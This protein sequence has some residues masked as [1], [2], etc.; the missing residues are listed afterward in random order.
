[1]ERNTLI[2]RLR[3]VMAMM[4]AVLLL[5]GNPLIAQAKS[6][7]DDDILNL[8]IGDTFQGGD[9]IWA[10]GTGGISTVFIDDVHIDPYNEDYYQND[11]EYSRFFYFPAGQFTLVLIDKGTYTSSPCYWILYFETPDRRNS[12]ADDTAPAATSTPPITFTTMNG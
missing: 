4:L 7:N 3:G 10:F 1:M 11:G 5:A 9:S 2:K 8:E 6:I 12:Q